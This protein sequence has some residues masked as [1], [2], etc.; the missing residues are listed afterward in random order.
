MQP[1]GEHVLA[2]RPDPAVGFA[3]KPRKRIVK[4][5][6]RTQARVPALF[7]DRT[8]KGPVFFIWHADPYRRRAT[9]RVTSS[10]IAL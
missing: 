2:A 4:V 8:G 5:K 3:Q 6:L 1:L 9:G 10:L 7:S